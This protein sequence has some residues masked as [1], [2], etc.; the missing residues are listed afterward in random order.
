MLKIKKLVWMQIKLMTL[1][2]NKTKIQRNKQKDIIQTFIKEF[3]YD[4]IRYAKGI[5][6]KMSYKGNKQRFR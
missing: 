2:F 4:Y 5:K 6:N 1:I 3:Y